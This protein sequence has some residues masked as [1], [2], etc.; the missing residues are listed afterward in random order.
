MNIKR[1]GDQLVLRLDLKQPSYDATGEFTHDTDNLIGVIAGRD[2]SISQLNDL[3]YKGTQQEGTPYIMFDSVEELIEVCVEL[4][5]EII[6]HPICKQCSVVI[7]GSHTWDD[8]PI[9]LDNCKK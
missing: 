3:G 4:G 9:C 1:E 7:R 6:D 2:Y 8:G 5:I